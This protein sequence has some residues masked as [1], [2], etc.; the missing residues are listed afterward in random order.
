MAL[1]AYVMLLLM[2]PLIIE[3]A[4]LIKKKITV[5]NYA[6][7]ASRA[8]SLAIDL[9]THYPTET[10]NITKSRINDKAFVQLT[11]CVGFIG[12]HQFLLVN[13]KQCIEFLKKND[14][15]KSQINLSIIF[16]FTNRS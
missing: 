3:K 4:E 5:H 11:M 10:F 6:E 2:T 7:A 8:Y 15:K 9:H 14:A 16:E 13:I 12:L 1:F